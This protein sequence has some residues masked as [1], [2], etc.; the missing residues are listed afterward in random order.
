[1][2]ARAPTNCSGSQSIA[3]TCRE[4]LYVEVLFLVLAHHH[5]LHREK[6]GVGFRA[7]D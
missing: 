1:M 3:I 5:T 2:H 7:R 6:I 4:R